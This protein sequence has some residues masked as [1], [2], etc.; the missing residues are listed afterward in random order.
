MLSIQAKA[1]AVCCSR[2]AAA[3]ALVIKPLIGGVETTDEQEWLT[4]PLAAIASG[5]AVELSYNDGNQQII[6]ANFKVFSTVQEDGT[7]LFCYKGPAPV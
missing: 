2:R 7:Y 3:K 6:A 4:F 1:S 5:Q